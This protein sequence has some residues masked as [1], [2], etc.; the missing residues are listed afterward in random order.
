MKTRH[1]VVFAMLGVLLPGCG[2]Q[3]KPI[4]PRVRLAAAHIL[5]LHKGSEGSTNSR[6]KSEARALAA[7]I[8]VKARAK[9][10]DFTA[11]AQ[12]YSEGPSAPKGGEL[13]VFM[14][15]DMVAKFATGLLALEIGEV[16]DPVETKYGYHII[17]RKKLDLVNAKHILIQWEGRDNADS[18]GVDRTQKEALTLIKEIKQKCADGAKF[19]DL[20][21]EYSEGPS[22]GDGGDLG[23]FGRTQM[24]PVFTEA[25][26][27]LELEGVS[28]VVETKFGYHIIYRYE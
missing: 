8:A 19:E 18:N 26:F 9:D 15:G 23:E 1:F 16:S 3:Q 22:A 6:S 21:K 2:G 28:D 24:V 5:I 11:L 27:A 14:S 20:A 13:G 4:P 10:A 17:F 12:K 25:A 7:E